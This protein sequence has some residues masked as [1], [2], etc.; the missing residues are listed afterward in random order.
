[1]VSVAETECAA[2]SEIHFSESPASRFATLRGSFFRFLL[3]G[4]ANTL[5]T[6]LLMIT[7][8]RW[9]EIE[10]AYTIVFILGLI[11]TTAVA[12]PF[13][14][15]SRLTIRALRRF[16]SWYLCVYLVGVTVARLAGHHWHVSHLVTTV[17]VIAITA[18][19]NFLGGRRAFGVRAATA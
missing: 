9:V 14:F 17:A 11:F 18:P 6:G 3:A 1:M 2:Q 5:I 15:R 8:A 4:A 13:V 19:L 16:V 12:G 7:I 10:I